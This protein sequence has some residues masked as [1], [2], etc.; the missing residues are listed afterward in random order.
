MPIV[1]TKVPLP[2]G[3]DPGVPN[4]LNSAA[5]GVPV[6]EDE[7]EVGAAIRA[8]QLTY[9]VFPYLQWRYGD[10][11]EKFTNS[12]S[13][14]LAWL[15][16][17]DPNR[18]NEQIK[19]LWNILSNRGMPGIILEVHL[20]F[21]YRQLCLSVPDAKPKHSGLLASADQIRLVSEAVISDDQCE[22]LTVD[23]SR[24]MRRGAAWLNRGT[25]R[26][27]VSA[28]VDERI[29]IPNSVSS[30][31]KWLLSVPKLRAAEGLRGS[32]SS[33]ELRYIDSNQFASTWTHAIEAATNAAR[34]KAETE[35]PER[36]F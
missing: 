27:L 6:P 2:N 5:G 34:A 35:S 30:L 32:L 21:L 10:R 8:G 15:T 11:G 12:D 28:A 1:E 20:R 29:G 19:W 7:R 31:T 9:R 24:G 4:P 36:L 13:A 16:R 33:S 3:S 26:L 17:Y 14:W 25:C 18:V 23:F 22:R